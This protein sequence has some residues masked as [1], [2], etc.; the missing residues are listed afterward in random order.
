M[1]SSPTPPSR[2]APVTAIPVPPTPR[3]PGARPT[4]GRRPPSGHP[5]GGAAVAPAP[6]PGPARLGW[7]AEVLRS[8][9]PGRGHRVH[10]PMQVAPPRVGPHAGSADG[11][12][13]PGAGVL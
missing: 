11:R 9:Q 6:N 12:A 3:T 10:L 2:L 13:A 8:G 7:P 1:I 4:G 5:A